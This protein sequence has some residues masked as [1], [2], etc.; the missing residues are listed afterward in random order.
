M[1]VGRRSTSFDEIALGLTGTYER[2]RM[3]RFQHIVE[4][5]RGS[6]SRL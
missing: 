6:R 2:S 1:F 4:A 5:S 3:F